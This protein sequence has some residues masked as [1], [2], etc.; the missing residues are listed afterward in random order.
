[1][2]HFVGLHRASLAAALAEAAVYLNAGI[3]AFQLRSELRPEDP[4]VFYAVYDLASSKVGFPTEPNGFESALR[5][6]PTSP[7]E[8]VELGLEIA[9]SNPVRQHLQTRR[10]AAQVEPNLTG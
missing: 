2:R 5:P 3:T 4:E 6:A 9:R 1:M 8:L 7:K 10:L